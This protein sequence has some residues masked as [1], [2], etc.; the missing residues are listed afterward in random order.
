MDWSLLIKGDTSIGDAQEIECSFTVIA[1]IGFIHIRLC[2]HKQAGTL[3]IPLELN[4]VTPEE[5]LLGDRAVELWH[6]EDLDCCR[7]TLHKQDGVD[8]SF[9]S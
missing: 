8:I 9:D 6:E 3:R 1:L 4:L 7:L 5:C 2:Q